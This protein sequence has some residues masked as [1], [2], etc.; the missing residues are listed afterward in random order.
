VLDFVGISAAQ[1]G[2]GR[3]VARGWVLATMC[4][5]RDERAPQVEER[6][7]HIERW[8]EFGVARSEVTGW[9]AINFGP[10]EAAMAHGD[11][12]T[13]SSAVHHRRQLHKVARSWEHVGLATT[14]GMRWH[15]AAFSANEAVR[16]RSRGCD[17]E[18]ARS[19][20]A[21]YH[22]PPTRPENSGVPEG[23]ALREERQ[24]Q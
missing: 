4:A 11:G 1:I 5:L 14:E 15:R 12:F 17:M 7:S 3:T 2:R 16:W 22:I 8:D 20:R 9:K 23:K 6:V 24:V 19:R 21:G 10:F 18:T 13:P